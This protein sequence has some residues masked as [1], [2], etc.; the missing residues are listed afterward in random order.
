MNDD[1]RKRALTTIDG[2]LARA[3]LERV[4]PLGY[5]LPSLGEHNALAAIERA[6]DTL[7]RVARNE[8]GPVSG[9]FERKWIDAGVK[10]ADATQRKLSALTAIIETTNTLTKAAT[11]SLQ[12]TAAF[13]AAFMAYP[14]TVA[15]IAAEI[16][17]AGARN[18]VRRRMEME[19]DLAQMQL[20]REQHHKALLSYQPALSAHLA[21]EEA[22]EAEAFADR[23]DAR[24]HGRPAQHAAGHRRQPD[25]PPSVIDALRAEREEALRSNDHER[26]RRAEA[27]IAQYMTPRPARSAS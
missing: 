3:R 27:A 11:H 2:E 7:G 22:L 17:H 10:V 9:W 15:D 25:Q 26:L 23:E 16:E 1:E 18:A 14:G 6:N 13:Q 20:A 12:H 5:V 4:E 8:I 19:G 24:R 21:S